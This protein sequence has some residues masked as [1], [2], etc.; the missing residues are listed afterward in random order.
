MKTTLMS[1][2]RIIAI[3]SDQEN[4]F[5]HQEGEAIKKRKFEIKEDIV[6]ALHENGMRNDIFRY[7]KTT[8]R[9]RVYR[10]HTI[11]FTSLMASLPN[12]FEIDI[13]IFYPL[14]VKE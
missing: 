10:S 9:G 1:G 14:G 11:N 13:P 3:L 5:L 6:I 2:R 8:K 4:V 12:V 7:W